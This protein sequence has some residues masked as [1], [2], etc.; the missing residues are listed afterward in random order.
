[1]LSIKKKMAGASVV[2]STP[3]WTVR[4]QQQQQRAPGSRQPA[5]QLSG[6]GHMPFTLTCHTPALPAWGFSG[7]FSG[8]PVGF[9]GC[10]ETVT[11]LNANSL[12]LVVTAVWV[13]LL[14]MT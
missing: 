13:D 7:P 12:R 6:G 2:V 8:A 4:R 3:F 11:H 14:L 9:W 10:K 1:M 5:M